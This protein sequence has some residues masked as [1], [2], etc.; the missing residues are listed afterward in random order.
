MTAISNSHNL[1]EMGIGLN[2]A[3]GNI[4]SG[5]LLLTIFGVLL[6]ILLR[7]TNPTEAFTAASTVCVI[8]SL[9]M[10]AAEFT[11]VFFVILFMLIWGISAVALYLVNNR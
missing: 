3:S 10:L 6:I 11:S 7:N 9:T 2:T 1:L 8:I 5:M 4:F